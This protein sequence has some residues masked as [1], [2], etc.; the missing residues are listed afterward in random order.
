MLAIGRALMSRPRVLLLD[1]PSLG[2]SP[3][4]VQQIFAIIRRSTARGRRS[5]SSS[6]TRSRRSRSRIAATCCRPAR[7]CWRDRPRKL[8]QR[9]G[10][11]D[12]PRRGLNRAPRVLPSRAGPGGGS[13]V[14]SLWLLVGLVAI[15]LAVSVLK[16]WDAGVGVA[17]GILDARASHR[18]RSRSAW[19]RPPRRPGVP[20][21]ASAS[22][23]KRVAGHLPRTLR[24]ADRPHLADDRSDR[25]DGSY[26]PGHPDRA[27]RLD[28]CTDDRL[29]LTGGRHRVYN[30]P[31]RVRRLSRRS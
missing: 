24:P 18:P 22:P 28:P 15:G 17:P 8:R 1:E 9:G 7:S 3:I 5:C 14:R 21:D 29:V 12:V 23:R 31:V 16:P 20:S 11:Q 2:L 10:P 25:C 26:R 4:L 30:E 19:H 27:A 6:R 13:N